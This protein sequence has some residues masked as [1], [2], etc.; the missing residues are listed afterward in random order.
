M[1][2][3]PIPK[4]VGKS[5]GDILMLFKQSA[6]IG[7]YNKISNQVFINPSMD[8]NFKAEDEVIAIT[9]DDDTLIPSFDSKFDI[10]T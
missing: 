5:Y 1:Y 7:V 6:V 4:L 9:S 2:A 10:L 3:T 8:Y